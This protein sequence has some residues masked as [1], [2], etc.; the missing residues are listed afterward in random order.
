[1]S[2]FF[3][4]LRYAL[5][6]TRARWGFSVTA[7]ASLAL[8]IAAN[9]TLFTVINSVLLR[10]P[11]AISSPE[12]LTTLYQTTPRGGLG[13]NM[14]VWAY[15]DYLYYRDANDVFSGLA[16]SSLVPVTLTGNGG[17]ERAIGEIVSGNYFSVMG[18]RP[19]LGRGFSVEEGESPRQVVVLS[20]DWWRNRFGAGPNVVGHKIIVNGRGFTVIG[21]APKDLTDTSVK[22][23]PSM[24]LPMSVQPQIGFPPDPDVLNNRGVGWLTVQGRLKSGISRAQA[25]TSL[26][27]VAQQLAHAYPDPEQ[28]RGIAIESASALP[29]F[30]RGI[31]F[32]AVALVQ[33]LGIV[34]MLIPCANVANLLLARS[35]GRRRELAIRSAVGATRMRIIQ[36]LLIE[37]G[38]LALLAGALGLVLSFAATDLLLKLRVP[39]PVPIALDFHPDFRVI[40]FTV[41][42]SLFTVL[43]FGLAP[44]LQTARVEL[45]D[46]LKSGR[47]STGPGR[48]S[49]IRDLLVVAQVAL[50]FVLLFEAALCMENLRWTESIDQGFQTKNLATF[51]VTT[52]EKGRSPDALRIEYSEMLHRLESVRGVSSASMALVPPLALLDLEGSIKKADDTASPG[53]AVGENFVSPHF[54]GTLGIGL[55]IGRDFL[56]QDQD[57]KVVIVNRRI[58]KLLWPAQNPVGKQIVLGKDVYQV[59]GVVQDSK[60]RTLWEAPRAFIYLPLK[61]GME[62]PLGTSVFL[63]TDAGPENVLPAIRK[64]VESLAN[65]LAVGVVET[66]EQRMQSALWLPRFVA[67]IFAAVGLLGMFLAIVGV[68]AI[69]AASVANRTKE[70]GIRIAVGANPGTVVREIVQRSMSLCLSGIVLGIPLAFGV[71]YALSSLLFRQVTS[72]EGLG[73]AVASLEL[74]VVTTTAC[75]VP[76]RKVTTTDPLAALRYE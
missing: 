18:V 36:Q 33:G 47:P 66:G 55:L 26:T 49:R 42:I 11:A 53:F 10:P 40:V 4:D 34:V 60:Y 56:A 9:V 69:T 25:L 29:S 41:L 22:L 23:A 2:N 48:R 3:H 65:N 19:L 15:P 54:F 70:I 62:G 73:F 52:V 1:M 30:F 14:P 57:A 72:F 38:I 8:G 7:I 45:V 31:V 39:L 21:V 17:E 37:A 13:G 68:Y 61:F 24:W 75:Y 6:V 28:G 74:L 12:Q 32:G 20:Y 27:R 35:F 63:R 71:S 16:A 64:T 59:I 46:A 50:S 58:S 76:A 44:A 5:R 51:T 43:L 67:G